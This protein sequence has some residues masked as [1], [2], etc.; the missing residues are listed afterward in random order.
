ME[1]LCVCTHTCYL[2]SLTP[3]SYEVYLSPSNTR[4]LRREEKTHKKVRFKTST[5]CSIL[6][7]CKRRH[8]L[9]PL[10]ISLHYNEAQVVGTLTKVNK[11]A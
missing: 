6:A 3:G 5:K 8:L 9:P 1:N 7:M 10:S 4:S 11:N 2:F